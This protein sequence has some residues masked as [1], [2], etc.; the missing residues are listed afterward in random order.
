MR[1]ADQFGQYDFPKKSVFEKRSSGQVPQLKCAW[2]EQVSWGTTLHVH[3]GRCYL[4]LC[5]ILAFLE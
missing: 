2:M 1:Y 5:C 3:M 4:H